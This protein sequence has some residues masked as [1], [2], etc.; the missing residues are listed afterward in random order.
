MAPSGTNPAH[1][2]FLATN[3]RKARNRT[4][5]RPDVDA[6][7]SAQMRGRAL[8][9]W[10]HRLRLRLV[11]DQ[12]SETIAKRA[13]LRKACRQSRRAPPP[14]ITQQ[15]LITKRSQ[16]RT[17]ASATGYGQNAR[18]QGLPVSTSSAWRTIV[19]GSSESIGNLA[20][21]YRSRHGYR[22][23]HHPPGACLRRVDRLGL[24]GLCHQ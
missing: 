6:L 23:S 10:S 2:R 24:A 4:S 17:Q 16:S 15:S 5:P 20:A 19:Q 13:Q 21:L 1:A 22:Q 11:A 12:K 14:G 8:T 7:R 18:S 3:R 9:L